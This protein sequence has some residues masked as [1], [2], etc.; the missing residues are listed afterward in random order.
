MGNAPDRERLARRSL[1]RQGLA[2]AIAMALPLPAAWAQTTATLEAVMVTAQR[3]VEN[4]QQ[5]PISVTA[6]GGEKLDILASGADDIKFLSA[7]LPSLLIESSFGRAFPRFYIRGLGNTDFDLNASQPV[8]LVYDDVVQENPILKGFPVFDLEQV[9][10]F[11]GP[12]GTLFGRNTPA[13]VVKFNSVRPSRDGGGYVQAS[14]G[15]D[16]NTNVEGAVGGALGEHWAARFSGLYQH[17]DNW[18]DNVRPAPVGVINKNAFEGFN[19][20]AGRL[21]FLY[22]PNDTFSALINIHARSL[23]GSARMFRANII[24]PGTNDL[25]SGFDPAQVS[26]DG[27]NVQKLDSSGG[28]VRLRWDFGRVTLHSITGYETVDVYSRGDIDGGYGAAFIGPPPLSGPGFIPFPAQSADGLPKHEQITQELRWESREWGAFDWQAGVYYFDENITIDSFDYN[29]LASGVQDGYAQ[30]HQKNTSWAVFGSG[31]YEVSDAF[32]LRGGLRYTNDEKDFTAQRFQSPFGAPPLGPISAHPSDSEVTGDVS[33]TWK[34][35][36]DTN[37]FVRVA[38]GY[39][40]PSIQGRILF[41][42]TVSV[43][44]A[45]TILSYEAGVKT[46]LFDDR[47]RLSF[48]VYKYTMDNQQ[49]TAVGGSTNFNTLINANK[50]DGQGFELDFEAKPVESLMLTVGLSYNDTQINDSNLEIQPCGG[51]CTVLDPAGSLPG[52]VSIDGNRLPQSPEWIANMTARWGV[53]VGSGEFFV[54]TDWAYRSDINFFLYDSMEFKGKAL[55]E[56]GLRV[57]YDWN[58]GRQ[59]LAFFGRNITDEIQA[60]GGIDFNNLTGF[61]NEPRRWGLEFKTKF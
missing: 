32:T 54:F 15:D 41:G 35:N 5:V 7:R 58:D 13:G 24:E 56:G 27:K 19:E 52:L 6:V 14:Y 20:F 18:V 53:P 21:Q 43:A 2:A 1:A 16:G 51:G 10:M 4:V 60:V 42:D 34:F 47:G 50:T 33:G 11:R 30:Q 39:R 55:L 9:E 49:L 29:T 57:G 26:T 44:D 45:E 28:S 37:L 25:V 40:A 12:Q 48:T 8:S 36:D 22:E 38:R 31:E 17:R 3:R 46:S 23:D 59:Q 61:I